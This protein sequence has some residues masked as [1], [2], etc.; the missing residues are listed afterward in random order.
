MLRKGHA[1]SAN[2]P[3]IGRSRDLSWMR[4]GPIEDEVRRREALL[5]AEPEEAEA[6]ARAAEK[7]ARR[8]AFGTFS[9]LVAHI[10]VQRAIGDLHTL[11]CIHQHGGNRGRFHVHGWRE[12]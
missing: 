1:P 5:A 9:T 2:R 4:R 7:A 12:R 6:A 11:M 8:H 10:L 3:W